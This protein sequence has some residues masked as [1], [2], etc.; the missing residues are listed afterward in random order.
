M[1]GS[2][3]MLFSQCNRNAVSADICACAWVVYMFSN[4]NFQL[5]FL[6]LVNLT[7]FFV[8]TLLVRKIRN[9]YLHS[10]GA[11]SS[12]L[13]YSVCIDVVCYFFHSS[14]V[15]DRNLLSYIWNGVAFNLKYALL[16]GLV[17][18]VAVVLKRS[19]LSAPPVRV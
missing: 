15:F 14:F 17:L 5:T 4:S 7:I 2:L 8:V 3:L 6:S 12:I 1:I 18:A 16:N 13:L 19:I 9:R 10:L 11:I